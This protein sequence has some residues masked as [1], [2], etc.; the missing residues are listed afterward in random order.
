MVALEMRCL[1]Q[2]DDAQGGGDGAVGG[3]EDRSGEQHLDMR[4]DP[5]GEEWCE[6]AEQEYHR[7][8]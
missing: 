1:P 4:P 3:R 7:G 2:A 6:G 5:F 8:R